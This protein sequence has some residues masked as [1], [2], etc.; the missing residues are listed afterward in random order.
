LRRKPDGR[1]C[2]PPKNFNLM[3]SNPFSLS[4]SLAAFCLFV[5]FGLSAQKDLVA[6]DVIFVSVSQDTPTWTN[7]GLYTIKPDGSN[8]AG[9]FDFSG[10]PRIKSGR[11]M[12]LRQSLDKKHLYFHSNHAYIYTPASRNLFRMEL[13]SRSLDQITPGPNS[14]E[15]GKEGNS[16]VSGFVRDS[17]GI[18]YSGTPVYLEGMGT[19]NTGGD[20]A[21][22][23]SKVPAGTRWL[24]AYNRTLDLFEARVVT[25]VGGTNATGLNLVPDSNSRMTFQH[26]VPVGDRVY[27]SAN[28][29]EV[30]WTTADFAAP[31]S[32]YK[33]KAGICSGIPMV[34]AFDV[35]R[36]GKIVVYDYQT[37]CGVGNRDHVGLY[38]MDKDGGNA[39]ILRDMLND[40]EYPQ[41]DDPVLPVQIFWSPDESKI[42]M[43]TSYGGIDHVVVLGADGNVLGYTVADSPTAV[44][45]LHGW[46]PDGNWLLFSEYN[47]DPAQASLGKIGVNDN[48]SIGAIGILLTNLAISS[49]CWAEVDPN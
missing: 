49:A 17:A 48:G 23:F 14:G 35:S 2:L 34:D 26:P 43:K 31:E 30:N 3:N 39:Q 38:T 47:S 28:G 15:F 44:A 7:D 22:S 24:V 27:Y 9:F 45:T 16:A 41:W 13:A 32:V 10:Q 8:S 5:I 36:S 19:I 11:I 42:A 4:R 18:G 29:M 20:G 12:G 6:E 46:S 1:N 25:I 21:F 33:T 37:G 40:K